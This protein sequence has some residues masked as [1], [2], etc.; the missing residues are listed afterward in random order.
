MVS[1]VIMVVGFTTTCAISAYP[2]YHHLSCEFESCSWQSVHDTTLFNKFVGEQGF[3]YIRRNLKNKHD[4][5][6]AGVKKVSTLV[7]VYALIVYLRG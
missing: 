7:H 1:C 3:E 2:R 4:L 6:R 5:K